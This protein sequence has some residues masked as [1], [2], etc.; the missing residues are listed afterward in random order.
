[1]RL[2]VVG[3]IQHGVRYLLTQ[4]RAGSHLGGSW[5]FP[6]GKVEAGEAP[7]DALRR[8][9]REELGAELADSE[10]LV[11]S[12]HRYPER[13]VLVLFYRCTLQGE[14]T[15]S[16]EGLAVRWATL[17]EIA[18]LPFPEAN[19]PALRLLAAAEAVDA[20]RRD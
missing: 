9:L 4:R 1:M 11:F 8:E 17:D 6:G 12:H 18:V 19:A 13:E 15:A 2:V 3:I 14:V 5:E 20:R 7:A 16:P 10:P